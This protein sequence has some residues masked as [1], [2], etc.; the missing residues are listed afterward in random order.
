MLAG[1]VFAGIVMVLTEGKIST[2]RVATLRLFIAGFIVLG[3]DSYSF[4]IL[5]GDI[6]EGACGRVWTESLIAS[7]MLVVGTVAVI[8]GISWLLAA[9]IE[10]QGNATPEQS[11]LGHIEAMRIVERLLRR[12][13]YGITVMTV[14]LLST[15]AHD[16]V[17]VAFHDRPKPWWATWISPVYVLLVGAAM[18]GAAWQQQRTCAQAETNAGEPSSLALSVAFTGAVSYAIVGTGAIGFITSTPTS[19]WNPIPGAVAFI[20]VAIVLIMPVPTILTLIY[21]MPRHGVASADPGLDPSPDPSPDA[22]PD[23]GPVPGPDP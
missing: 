16:Y 12:S 13:V 20:T 4:S 7:G 3:L 23:P 14:I 17:N 2:L 15:V 11:V 1:F 21:A 9:Y 5:T 10:N 19:F 22:G 18:I 6:A 8:S